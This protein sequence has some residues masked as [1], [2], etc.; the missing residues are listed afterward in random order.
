VLGVGNRSR[1]DDGAGPEVVRRLQG[2]V[3]PGVDLLE[4]GGDP[5][6]L[7]ERWDGRAV[8]LIVDAARSGGEPGSLLRFEG[9][10][11]PLAPCGRHRSTHGMGVGEAIGLSGALGRLPRRLVLY[12]IE[13]HEF[14]P[15]E[16]LSPEVEQGVEK[17]VRAVL[18]DLE[19]L[20]SPSRRLRIEVGGTVQGV[21]FRPH[22]YR[23]ARALDLAGWVANANHGASIEVEGD[24]AGLDEFSRALGEQPPPHCRVEFLGTRAIEPAGE[25]TFRIRAS[26]SRGARTAIALP[27][28]AVCAD[29]LH[30]LR[31]PADR[32][33]RYPFLNCTQCGPRFSIIESLP[34][35]R[36]RTTMRKFDMCE[37]CRAEYDDPASRRFHA[38]PNACPR[39]GPRL[40]ARDRSGAALAR[41]AEALRLAEEA[42]RAGLI[43]AV[44][45]L[46][47]FQLLVR[48]GD[49]APVL[50]LR[51]RKLREEKP[52]AL[53]FPGLEP[54]REVCELDP[55]EER[56][57]GSPQAPIVLLR[58]LEQPALRIA[59]AVA[60]G[61][62]R[63]GIMLP[64]TPLHHL[65]LD[66]LGFPVVATSGNLSE[67]PICIDDDVALARLNG[68]ADLF[69]GHDRPI[70][71]HVDDSVARVIDGEAMLLRRAR[72]YAPLPID[73]GPLAPSR[74]VLGVG[75]QMKNTVGLSVDGRVLLSQHIGD[76]S[77]SAAQRAFERV[78]ED[79]SGFYDVDPV[80]VACDSHP[81]Y[82]STRWAREAGRPLRC[83]Q[84]H[85]AHVLSCMADNGLQGPVLGV[86]WDGTGHGP[87]G[88]VWGGEFLEVDGSRWNRFAHLRLFRLPGGER[89]VQEPRRAAVGLLHELLGAAAF[90]RRELEPLR[91][92]TVP[93]R[94]L[95][96]RMLARGINS[97]TTSSAG[98]LFDA[99]AAM[100][101]LRQKSGFEGQ[102][103]M[104][105][106]F[107][108][109]ACFTSETYPFEIDHRG[110][111]PL[112]ADW[113]PMVRAIL[114][115]LSLGEPA[116]RISTRFHN[117]LVE[118]I[119]EVARRSGRERVLLTGGCFQ[120]RYLLE[121]SLARLG[122]VGLRAYRHRHVPPN[123]GG[124]ALGQV[125]WGGLCAVATEEC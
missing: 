107:A 63:L 77:A 42:L 79:L 26:D 114:E 124:V 70:A 52:L 87:D 5:G 101:G 112:V 105:L 60:P 48:A 90:E 54:V 58:R 9:A 18:R 10:E 92:F 28:L 3:P 97:P 13:A 68:V 24:P 80:L 30:E 17:A 22:V 34:Y 8:A 104:E 115:D 122:R 11:A 56:L 75:A 108:A 25:T 27:D 118:I 46:G 44:K 65:L 32:R 85:L 117:T 123:D 57:L 83:C 74:P 12:A 36:S 91:S 69:L 120:N 88:T 4:S 39:C 81:D 43:V 76:L 67:E 53:L 31:D 6:E 82:P 37:A 15:G 94:N 99:V 45:G 113:G 121:R 59:E 125:V 20:A 33:H 98:R 84:H 96:A 110:S 23:L 7:M 1:G 111:G 109:E 14:S 19:S 21:G 119:V 102:A 93:E 2:R 47:G 86:A 55:E 49:E 62:P 41:E 103:A 66:D 16:P 89:A 35:D 72:G 61:N 38:Q 50:R 51:R 116:G 71:R 73:P 29:C 95:L 40:E 64:P 78:I 106:E 100:T